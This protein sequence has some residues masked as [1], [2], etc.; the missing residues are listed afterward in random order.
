M[1]AVAVAGL[2]VPSLVLCR[3]LLGKSIQ[4]RGIPASF[5]SGHETDR[6]ADGMTCTHAHH[7]PGLAHQHFPQW[8]PLERHAVHHNPAL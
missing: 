2:A 4:L 7:T 3:Y 5:V 6:N 1:N 8:R